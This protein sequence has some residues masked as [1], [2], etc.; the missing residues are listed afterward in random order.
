MNTFYNSN[1]P[2]NSWYEVRVNDEKVAAFGPI[3]GKS[4]TRAFKL[5]DVT[6]LDL[7]RNKVVTIVAIRP[8]HANPTKMVEQVIFE[9]HPTVWDWEPSEITETLGN[10]PVKIRMQRTGEH[11]VNFDLQCL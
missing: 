5:V 8:H 11:S 3:N 7:Y 9:T 2:I 6:H 1:N 10:T 4:S